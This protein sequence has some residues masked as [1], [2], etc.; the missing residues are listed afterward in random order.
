[1]LLSFFQKKVAVPAASVIT[2]ESLDER[3]VYVVM[4]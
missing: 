1:L 4:L 3:A 2:K